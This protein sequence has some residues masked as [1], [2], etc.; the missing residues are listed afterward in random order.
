MQK[1]NAKKKLINKLGINIEN[2]KF[3]FIGIIN[4]INE[5]RYF[6]EIDI[7]KKDNISIVD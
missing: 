2:N 6:K 4:E 5:E 7:L 1:L 3:Y